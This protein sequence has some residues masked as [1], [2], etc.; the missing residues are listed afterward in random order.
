MRRDLIVQNIL[1]NY[2]KKH[3]ITADMVN[4]LIDSGLE[5]G[6]SLDVIYSGIKLAIS[7]VHNE[8]EYFTIDDV[9]AVT[10]ETPD[11]VVARI[12]AM[13][14]ELLE[15]GENPNDYFM[16]AQPTIKFMM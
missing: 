3:N 5:S 14:D 6:I 7:N 4:Q 8:K 16:K 12:E 1:Y 10:G 2:G 9:C 11:E 13:R 15:Q